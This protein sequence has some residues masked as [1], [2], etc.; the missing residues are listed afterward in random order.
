LL[1]IKS[2]QAAHSTPRFAQALLPSRVH[3]P[4]RSPPAAATLSKNGRARLIELRVARAV[5][6]RAIEDA[7][8]PLREFQRLLIER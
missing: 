3:S 8:A 6:R 4:Y 7:F 2:R 1:N 5:L